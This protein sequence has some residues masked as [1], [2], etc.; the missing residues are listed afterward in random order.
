MGGNRLAILLRTSQPSFDWLNGHSLRSVRRCSCG[1][2]ACNFRGG[3]WH[4]VLAAG[5][6]LG[7]QHRR[8]EQASRSSSSSSRPTLKNKQRKR[9]TGTES[10]E[11]K[12]RKK[13]E[14]ERRRQRG[15]IE[16][17][18]KK[19]RQE[20]KRMKRKRQKKSYFYCRVSALCPAPKV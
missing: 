8:W 7:P 19:K 10:E 5:S 17:E 18:D 16:E 14:E 13:E 12:K 9:K 11:K 6:Q 3:S 20:D 4:T 15:R 1:R 2:T